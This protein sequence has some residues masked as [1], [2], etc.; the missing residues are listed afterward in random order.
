MSIASMIGLLAK[1]LFAAF[2]FA[3]AMAATLLG[4]FIGAAVEK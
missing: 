4:L 3:V 2:L 1:G